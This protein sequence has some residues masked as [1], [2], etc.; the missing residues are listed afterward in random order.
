MVHS[1]HEML[2]NHEKNEV[3]TDLQMCFTWKNANIFLNE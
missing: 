2:Y 1:C 3:D